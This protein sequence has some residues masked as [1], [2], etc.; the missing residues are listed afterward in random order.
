MAQEKWSDA[1]KRTPTLSWSL[2]LSFV[3]SVHFIA[4]HKATTC[5]PYKVALLPLSL[6]RIKELKYSI[7]EKIISTALKL[8][9]SIQGHGNKVDFFFY[10]P[11]TWWWAKQ[12]IVSLWIIITTSYNRFLYLPQYI[13]HLKRLIGGYSSFTETG[14]RQKRQFTNKQSLSSS[15]YWLLIYEHSCDL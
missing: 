5:F 12:K 7:W 3:Y 13:Q 4:L 1:G 14:K 11:S 8:A 10:L 15:K 9:A 6:A 2:I